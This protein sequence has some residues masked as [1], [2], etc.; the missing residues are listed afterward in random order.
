M[1]IPHFSTHPHTSQFSDG[2]GD[3]GDGGGPGDGV[4]VGVRCHV[5]HQLGKQHALL[6]GA[7]GQL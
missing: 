4:V 5:P 7:S 1:Y 3:D 6:G 2:D